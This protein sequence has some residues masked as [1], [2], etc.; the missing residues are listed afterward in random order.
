MTFT[1]KKSL[2]AL[3]LSLCLIVS[4]FTV[5]VF[6]ESDTTEG[7]VEVVSGESDS[8]SAGE[9]EN[10]SSSAGNGTEEKSE[11]AT[12]EA[13]KESET[14]KKEEAADD[15]VNQALAE[16]ALAQKKAAQK[17]LIINAIIIAVIIII[18]VAVGIKFRVKL[19]AFFRSVKSE[20]GKI[21]WSGKENTRKSFLVVIVVAIVIAAVIWVLD[22]A[23]NTGLGMLGKLFG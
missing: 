2:I 22:L 15:S 7:I 23:F 19:A 14:E 1:N 21:V 5:A 4:L 13:S 9:L 11:E 6:A 20:L 3:L 8:T 17:V 16:A 12:T 10:E 18:L